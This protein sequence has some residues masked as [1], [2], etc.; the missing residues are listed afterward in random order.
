M[1]NCS[2]EKHRDGFIWNYPR[3]RGNRRVFQPR[4]RQTETWTKEES[5]E[6]EGDNINCAKHTG[7]KLFVTASQVY[8]FKFNPRQ[9]APVTTHLPPLAVRAP[10][11]M[12]YS[13]LGLMLQTHRL[14]KVGLHEL[15]QVPPTCSV[16][17][18]RMPG[19]LCFCPRIL[20]F[21]AAQSLYPAVSLRIPCGAFKVLKKVCTHFS[22]WKELLENQNSIRKVSISFKILKRGFG[23]TKYLKDHIKSV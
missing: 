10:C 20:R 15:G 12:K 9:A 5:R 14:L 17:M 7:N 6:Q 11:T 22:T 8:P 1:S 19:V 2:L 4:N 13:Y 21:K 16:E 23:K 3:W 18:P